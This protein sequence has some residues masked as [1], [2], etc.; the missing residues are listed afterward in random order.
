[1]LT[2][3]KYFFSLVKFFFKKGHLLGSHLLGPP[4]KLLNQPTSFVT[5]GSMIAW[6]SE[7][8]WTLKDLNLT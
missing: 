3:V 5:K 2:L 7:L 1:M 6:N 8:M 4:F